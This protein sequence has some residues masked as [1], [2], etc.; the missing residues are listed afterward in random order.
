MT[1]LRQWVIM[2]LVDDDLVA[3]LQVRAECCARAPKRSCDTAQRCRCMLKPKGVICVKENVSE[4]GFVVDREDS[5]V[6]RD[7]KHFKL[8]FARAGCSLLLE[9]QQQHFPEELKMVK[10][11]ALA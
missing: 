8:L 1:R 3:F 4:G 10:M 11:Y 5:S 2:F 7:D 6:M 9:A